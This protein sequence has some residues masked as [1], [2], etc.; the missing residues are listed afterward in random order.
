[1][2]KLLYNLKLYAPII[3]L[4][5]AFLIAAVVHHVKVQ[6]YK[7]WTS[8]SAVIVKIENRTRSGRHS[9]GVFQR[10]YF[11]FVVDGKE[12]IGYDDL[13]GWSNDISVNDYKGIWYDPNSPSR[14]RMS[15]PSPSFEMISVLLFLSP[16]VFYTCS[17]PRRKRNFGSNR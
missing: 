9:G 3:A 4:I 10:F 14:S 13:D 12:Y 15:K 6:E 11:S 16:L 5:I 8:A 17:I 2:E 7:N 1:M